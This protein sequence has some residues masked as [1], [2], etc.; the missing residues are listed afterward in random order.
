MKHGNKNRLA[1][2]IG[3][4]VIVLLVL[5]R[6]GFY[7]VKSDGFNGLPILIPILLLCFI[8]FALITS[9]LLAAW[10]YLDCKRRGDDPVLWAIV[11]FIAT[12]FIGLLIYFLRRK[13][14]LL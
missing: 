7:F 9:A 14:E 8:L 3:I 12:P 6:F 5:L 13:G 4:P 1:F 11:V 10:V 2:F